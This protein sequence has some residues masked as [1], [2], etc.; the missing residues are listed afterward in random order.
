MAALRRFGRELDQNVR[1]GPNMT[2]SERNEAIGM[3]RSGC[4]VAEV[5]D[6]FGRG[7]QT[8]RQASQW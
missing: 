1:R 7:R 5:A 3:L 4:S 2:I 6:H 8:I